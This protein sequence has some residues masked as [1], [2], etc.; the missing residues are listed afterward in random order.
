M[1]KSANSWKKRGVLCRRTTNNLLLIWTIVV[2]IPCQLSTATCTK[3]P[4]LACIHL[5]IFQRMTKMSLRLTEETWT[6]IY[7]LKLQ[8][9][10]QTCEHPFWQQRK[11]DRTMSILK[12]WTRQNRKDLIGWTLL[13]DR[14]VNDICSIVEERPKLFLI[15]S[16][17]PLLIAKQT[18]ASQKESTSGS[19][20]IRIYLKSF[21]IRWRREKHEMRQKRKRSK[22]TRYIFWINSVPPW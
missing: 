14:Q 21:T 6:Q 3:M 8:L 5:A 22:M 20:I 7:A 13:R 12:L 2:W 9:R 18:I 16:W 11:W 19:K 17:R 10:S 15:L 1:P 4:N